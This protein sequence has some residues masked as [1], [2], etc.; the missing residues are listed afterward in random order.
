MIGRP[1]AGPRDPGSD[2]LNNRRHYGRAAVCRERKRSFES[3]A[4]RGFR[5]YLLS[6]NAG[7]LAASPAAHGFLI[8]SELSTTA[9][10]TKIER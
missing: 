4:N 10:L 6:E 3:V 9:R 5:F 8:E 2:S 1:D 7:I